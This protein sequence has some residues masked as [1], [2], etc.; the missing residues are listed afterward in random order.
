MTDDW[1]AIQPVDTPE[2]IN[3]ALE[4]RAQFLARQCVSYAMNAKESWYP[5]GLLDYDMFADLLS[6]ALMNT[7]MRPLLLD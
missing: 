4:I 6:D 2:D 3:A 5:D 7:V 1:Y